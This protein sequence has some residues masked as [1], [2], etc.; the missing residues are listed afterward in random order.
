MIP[1]DVRQQGLRTTGSSEYSLHGI[2]SNNG[3]VPKE[4][5]VMSVDTRNNQ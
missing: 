3:T 1:V 2:A 5:S 4:N